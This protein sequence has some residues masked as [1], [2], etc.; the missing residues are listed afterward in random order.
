VSLKKILYAILSGVM[1]SAAFPPGS[2]DWI[3][4][5][6]IIPLLISLED[7]RPL[8]AF[9][10]G[11]I[12][13]LSHYLT[14][15]YWIIFVTNTYGGIDLFT[16][17]AILLLFS[18]YLSLY[19][20]VFSTLI[21]ILS[22]RRFVPII[23]AGI[24][25]SLE[26]LRALLI[27]GFPWCLLG[28]SQFSHLFVIQVSDITGVYGIS[29][30][31]VAVNALIYLLAFN[32]DSMK[33]K[34]WLILDT[35]IVVG[36]VLVCLN[37]GIGSLS[38]RNRSDKK[39]ESIITSVIQGNID[40]SVKWDPAYM[41]STMDTYIDLTRSAMNSRPGLIVWPES[42]APFFFQDNT[43]YSED[44]Y[45]LAQESGVW[46]IFGCPAYEQNGL[47]Y[48]YYNRVCLISPNGSFDGYYDKIHLVPFGEYVPLKRF[49]PFVHR[50]VASEGEFSP[51]K[52]SGLLKMHDTTTGALICYEAILPGLARKEVKNG[53]RILV[54]VTN[55]AW[56]GMTSAPNQHLAMCV[57]RAVENKR[58]LVRSANTGF[59]AFIDPSGRITARSDLFTEDILT[60][61]VRTDCDSITFYTRYG[62]I[63][64]YVILIIC[65][66]KFSLEL[67]YHLTKKRKH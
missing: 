43:E 28:Y 24:W 16:S 42:A 33:G 60:G 26:Y 25:V 65:L 35:S 37:Y 66:I 61:E 39:A 46:L 49:I 2:L 18:L 34:R 56:F 12:A 20:A 29:F 10:L 55:D 47:D 11:M 41:K 30:L 8:N 22:S 44:M 59:S 15:I 9:R 23:T 40:Q 57:F 67:C 64:V 19:P 50:L 48:I 13:G 62:D 27:T 21:R 63:F 38:D 31:I 58:P 17:S 54:N 5:I 32:R 1:L 53:A 14:L 3:A 4:W 52:E 7:E 45:K 51:G 6:A 36:L